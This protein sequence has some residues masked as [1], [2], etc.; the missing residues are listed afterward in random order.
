MKFTVLYTLHGACTQTSVS[1]LYDPKRPRPDRACEVC[2]TT[3]LETTRHDTTR[4]D[5]LQYSGYCSTHV[6]GQNGLKEGS[7]ASY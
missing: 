7:T 1:I 6:R 5:T 4:H 3:P 2:R